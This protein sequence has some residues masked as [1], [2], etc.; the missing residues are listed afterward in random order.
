MAKEKFADKVDIRDLPKKLEMLSGADFAEAER[1]EMKAGNT[2]FD[3]LQTRPY[4]VRVAA[5]ALN[6]KP[7]DILKLPGTEY[8][9]VLRQVDNFLFS[10]LTKDKTLFNLPDN[11]P[12]D[13]ESSEE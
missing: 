10:G 3:V 13:F 12:S 5:K 9:A 11:S 4:R 1:E 7:A 6:C 8:F 2:A